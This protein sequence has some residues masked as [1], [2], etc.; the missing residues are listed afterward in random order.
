MALPLLMH[1]NSVLLFLLDF[2]FAP[3]INFESIIE[4]FLVS[5]DSDRKEIASRCIRFIGFSGNGINLMCRKSHGRISNKYRDKL[6]EYGQ[7]NHPIFRAK[8]RLKLPA[9]TIWNRKDEHGKS[10]LRFGD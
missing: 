9:R 6:S 4:K 1:K 7:K 5:M 2:M 3:E 10:T 8:K